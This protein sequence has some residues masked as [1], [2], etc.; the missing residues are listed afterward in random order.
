M[1]TYLFRLAMTN[2]MTECAKQPGIPDSG[3][4]A[5]ADVTLVTKR[6]AGSVQFEVVH[7]AICA[8][9]HRLGVLLDMGS[10]ARS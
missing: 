3:C 4:A 9:A 8:D 1:I 5:P 2:E 7:T 6:F 10:R